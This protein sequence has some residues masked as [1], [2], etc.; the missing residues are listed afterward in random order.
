MANSPNRVCWDSC[1]WIARITEENI[2]EDGID[3]VTRCKTVLELAKNGKVEIACSALC[4]AEVCKNTDVRDMD[5]DKIAAF[6]EHDFI[7][8][9]SLGREVGEK[10]RDLMVANYP[11][12]KPPDACHLATAL[13]T[14][15]IQALHLRP[16]TPQFGWPT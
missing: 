14:P 8:P 6:F 4:W 15:G 12:L 7:L 3:R 2:V 9:V 13:L 16:K 10:A 11:G 1:C 5:G